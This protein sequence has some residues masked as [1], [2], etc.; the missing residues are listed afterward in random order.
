MDGGFSGVD[1]GGKK[2]VFAGCGRDG[3][4]GIF[5]VYKYSYAKT[6][7]IRSFRSAAERFLP[8]GFGGFFGV[9]LRRRDGEI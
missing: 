3:K 7:N 4:R 5:P 8:V 1:W 9:G 6:G 2:V